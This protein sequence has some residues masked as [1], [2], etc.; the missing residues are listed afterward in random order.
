MEIYTHL[1]GATYLVTRRDENVRT[2]LEVY[3]CANVETM[4]SGHE[5]LR[6]DP[7]AGC[8]AL[9]R[10]V[11]AAIAAMK[12]VAPGLK[13]KLSNSYHDWNGGFLDRSRWRW[14]GVAIRPVKIVEEYEDGELAE[15]M[16]NHDSRPDPDRDKIAEELLQAVGGAIQDAL[17]AAENEA[18]E[19]VIP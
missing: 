6:S 18:L 12:K 19:G 8:L 1:D 14:G 10:A 16:I 11:D 2:A 4:T 9:V 15:V 13:I 7:T 17:I 5:T 3:M